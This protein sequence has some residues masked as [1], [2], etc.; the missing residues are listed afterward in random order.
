MS[1]QPKDSPVKLSLRTVKL[2]REIAPEVTATDRNEL[3]RQLIQIRDDMNLG[4]YQAVAVWVKLRETG[5]WWEDFEFN[6][7]RCRS[8]EEFMVRRNLPIGRTLALLEAQVRLFSRETFLE[9]GSD[10]LGEMQLK[11]MEKQ[12]DPEMQLRDYAAIFANYEKEFSESLFDQVQ[13]R[14]H[15]HWYVN[16]KYPSPEPSPAPLVN[17]PDPTK[18]PARAEENRGQ[19]LRRVPM[20][21]N[22]DATITSQPSKLAH[23]EPG[24]VIVGLHREESRSSLREKYDMALHHIFMLEHDLREAGL[25]VR[26]RPPILKGH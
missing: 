10:L 15:V 4:K 12:P 22:D 11:V 17:P 26:E 8:A 9:L 16:T 14:Q 21:V 2:E 13:F 23:V 1:P 24:N 6:G 7:V 18:P 5:S 3:V 20:R 19:S 25:P